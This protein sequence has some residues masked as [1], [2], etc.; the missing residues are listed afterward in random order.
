MAPAPSLETPQ[1]GAPMILAFLRHQDFNAALRH[2]AV[3]KA[4]LYGDLKPLHRFASDRG[5]SLLGI[6]ALSLHFSD[7]GLSVGGLQAMRAESNFCSAGRAAAFIA[8]M[9]KRADFVPADN[10]PRRRV[11]KLVISERFVSFERERLRADVE[12]LGMLSPLGEFGLAHL[13]KPAFFA[14]YMRVAARGLGGQANEHVHEVEFFQ[15]RNT[16]LLALYD[17]IAGSE[18]AL[19]S[20]PVAVSISQLSKRFDVSR[21]HILRL[22]RDADAEGLVVWQAEER[23]VTLTPKLVRALRGYVA[24]ILAGSAYCIWMAAKDQGML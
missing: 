10:K 8:T 20:K 15:E 5:S 3:R 12:S 4:K 6:F 17:I 14:G 9:R 24:F 21:T 11:S 7:Q 1:F 19:E 23:L 2:S 13:D 18:D 22:L 16:G